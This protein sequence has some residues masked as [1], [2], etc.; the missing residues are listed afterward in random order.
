MPGLMDAVVNGSGDVTSWGYLP[1]SVPESTYG[2]PLYSV[3]G[4]SGYTDDRHY[5]FQSSMPVVYGMLQSPAVGSDYG[6]F[7]SAVYG[8]SQAMYNHFGRGFEGFY[9]IISQVYVPTSAA[10]AM[11][12]RV[13]KT[14]TTY[15][16]KFPLIGKVQQV[17]R[18]DV[19]TGVLLDQEDDTYICGL[20][21]RL[22][23]AQGSSLPT[24]SS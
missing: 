1:L 14:V 6:G 19:T 11:R 16:Q 17:K 7:R 5:Y 24:P 13:E 8:Y 10:A 2:F 12:A 15:N 20:G 21:S 22:A 3:P 18:Y 9:Q 4:G 23:C